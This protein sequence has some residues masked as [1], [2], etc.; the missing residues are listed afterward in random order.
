MKYAVYIISSILG[1]ILTA[2]VFPQAN[3]LGLEPDLLLVFTLC[4]V[5]ITDSPVPVIFT[6][7]TA[8]FIDMF[9]LGNVGTYTLPYIIVSLAVMWIWH[10][11]NKDRILSPVLTCA[12][13]WIVKDC[14]T[15]L[16]V[17]L[18]GNTF[19][20][21]KLFLTN[22]LPETLINC[23]L[24]LGFYQIYM[25]IFEGKVTH[26]MGEGPGESVRFRKKQR[27]AFKR[28]R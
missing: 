19:D 11:R 5:M 17:F 21:G 26:G 14:L 3:I 25:L 22:T 27:A 23:V 9:Y 20:F 10:G 7:V 4:L 15:A 1:G 24:M 16:M 12:A 13:A 6:G 2:S 8:L 18:N 28:S